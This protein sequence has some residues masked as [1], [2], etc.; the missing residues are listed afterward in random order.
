MHLLVHCRS[1]EKIAIRCQ[2]LAKLA[3]GIDGVAPVDI[4]AFDEKHFSRVHAIAGDI[5]SVV[6]LVCAQRLIE[7]LR[8]CP[9]LRVLL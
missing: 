3:G 5:D 2:V 7:R 8:R 4:G 6:L 9:A 1:N